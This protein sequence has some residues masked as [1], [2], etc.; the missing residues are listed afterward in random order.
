MSCTNVNFSINNTF[1]CN[2][3]LVGLRCFQ[4]NSEQ[5]HVGWPVDGVDKSKGDRENNPE[6]E[7]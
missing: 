1:T 7:Y 2:P 3:D 4:F 6:E 5:I